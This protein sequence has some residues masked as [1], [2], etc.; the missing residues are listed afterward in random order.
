MIVVAIPW[1]PTPDR[2][3]AF[4]YVTAWYRQHLPEAPLVC[5]DAGGE[6]F[7]RAGSRNSCVAAAERL[8]ADVVVL[9]DA[10]TVPDERALRDAIAAAGDGRLHFGLDRMAYLDEA[11]SEAVYRGEAIDVRGEPHDS[12]VLVIRPDAYWA[13][14]GQDERFRDY[15]GEDNA[16][17]AAATTLLGAPVWHQ[18]TA[19]SLWHDGACRDVGSQR[20]WQETVPL[21]RRY[22]AAKYDRSAMLA[23]IAERGGSS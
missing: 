22:Q 15:G 4:E 13:A 18:G 20:W 8:G 17:T 10:D 16:F 3:R 14:G 19:L 1:R 12:S 21:H 9:G 23:L 11:Q 2:L 7:S 5:A 6:R